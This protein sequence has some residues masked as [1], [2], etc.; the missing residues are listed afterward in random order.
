MVE[1]IVC[2]APPEKPVP[3]GRVHV[4]V[5]PV[6]ITPFTPSVGVMLNRVPPQA[7]KLI[8]ENE[9]VKLATGFT[10]TVMVNA[11]PVQPAPDTVVTW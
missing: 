3:V 1:P 8:C 6:G 9:E 11:F 4:Y 10:T 2:E 7:V 5:V